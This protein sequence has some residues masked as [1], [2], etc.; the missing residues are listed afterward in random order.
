MSPSLKRGPKYEK[1]QYS[2]DGTSV[3]NY[4]ELCRKVPA[5]QMFGQR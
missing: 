2:L 1:Y 5:S 3:A 4:L